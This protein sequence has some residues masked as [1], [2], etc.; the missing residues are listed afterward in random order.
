MYDATLGIFMYIKQPSAP[1]ELRN[2][3]HNIHA[4]DT[5]V[6][7]VYAHYQDEGSCAVAAK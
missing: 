2:S 5:K 1:L 6:Q 7:H 4:P 3:S